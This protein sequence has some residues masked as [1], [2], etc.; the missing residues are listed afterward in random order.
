MRREAAIGGYDRPLVLERPRRRAT[1]VDHRLDRDAE[2]LAD[3][4]GGA[5]AGRAGDG[6]PPDFLHRPAAPLAH[7]RLQDAVGPA[8]PEALARS[9]GLPRPC[10]ALGAR[11]L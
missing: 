1:D 2:P 10:A 7:A 4:R 9:A 3:R 8:A 6:P 11:R 5:G